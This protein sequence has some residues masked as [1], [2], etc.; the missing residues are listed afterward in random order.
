MLES[1]AGA[2]VLLSAGLLVTVIRPKALLFICHRVTDC[3]K[4]IAILTF[5]VLLLCAGLELVARG[6]SNLNR[7]SKPAEELVGEGKPRETVS[8]YSSQDWAKRY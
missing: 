8:Y 5:N 1:F 3:Y 7:L 2:G 4:A 6:I